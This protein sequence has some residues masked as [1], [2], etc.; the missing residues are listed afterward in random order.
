MFV[1]SGEDQ[2]SSGKSKAVAEIVKVS[3]LST[4]MLS[5]YASK[6]SKTGATSLRTSGH[7]GV[8]EGCPIHSA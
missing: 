4:S 2:L 7:Q 1:S 6:K 8:C 3:P 5:P